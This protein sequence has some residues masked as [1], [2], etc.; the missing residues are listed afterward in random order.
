VPLPST[1]LTFD[2][3]RQTAAGVASTGKVLADFAVAFLLDGTVQAITPT[4]TEGATSGLWRA[5]EFE[6][7]LPASTGI[8]QAFIDVAS[9][10]DSVGG[11]LLTLDLQAYNET[12]I[13]GLILTSQGVPGVRSAVP[14]D[15][16]EVV[17][18][19][20]YASDTLTVPLGKLTPFGFTDLAGL[21]LSVEARTG[22]GV[23]ASSVALTGTIV[24][25]ALRTFT[26]KFDAMPAS[27]LLTTQDSVV[28]YIDCQFR[29]TAAPNRII[30]TNR[31]YF[32]VVWDAN[33]T[34]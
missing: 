1:T 33:D 26:F 23:P 17:S 16:G 19:D 20:S 9:G 30:T 13:A 11:G 5:Y 15:L 22:P 25:S 3:W 18:G 24:S 14:N 27:M 4:V 7:T 8:F 28:W 32:S 12:S 29:E 34:P 21:T 2:V 6:L 10:T 31:Y